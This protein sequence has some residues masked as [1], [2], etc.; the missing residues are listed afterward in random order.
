MVNNEYLKSTTKQSRDN[1]KLKQRG[2]IFNQDVLFNFF[3][4]FFLILFCALILFPIFHIVSGS[5]SNPIELIKGEVK[6]LPKG[7]TLNMYR[8]VFNDN[9]IWRAYS[10]TIFYTILGTSIS[11]FLTSTAAYALSRRDF[12]GRNIFMGLFLF[13]MFFS[14]G[15]IP[16][17]LIVQR[18]G[19]LNTIW[20]MVLPS[21]I[22]TYNMIIMR[23]FFANS[24][25]F[26][27]T[28]SAQ[29]DGCND[30]KIFIK[31]AL[32]LS[33]PV[34]AVMTL[35]YGVSLWN[36]WFPALLYL[37]NRGLYPLQLVLREILLQ[38]DISNMTG[39]AGDVESIGEGLKYATMIV[40]TLPI[41]CLYPFLQRYFTKGVMI[42]AVKG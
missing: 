29:L 6:L 17:F 10:N 15:M 20:A 4:Y 40:A 13:T 2:K 33:G 12:Y 38:S 32:P 31:I 11:V 28:E 41:L 42:G 14:G 35:F 34:L 1:K 27:L 18:L 37:R 39:S 3:V 30:I 23:T 16:T 26:E 5:F 7:F 24:I 36:S 22:S 8:K 19:M 21:A 9:S 25:P